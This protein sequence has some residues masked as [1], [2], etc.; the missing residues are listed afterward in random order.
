MALKDY[1]THFKQSH[2]VDGMKV[3]DFRGKRS[4]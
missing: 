2:Q 3:E 1:L 4:A